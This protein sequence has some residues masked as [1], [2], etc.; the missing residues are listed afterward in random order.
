MGY[1]YYVPMGPFG[2]VP[3]SFHSS[4][5]ASVQNTGECESVSVW[6]LGQPEVLPI[7]QLVL[8]L[9]KEQG[10]M[11]HLNTSYVENITMEL[12]D[13]AP[14]SITAILAWRDAG[15]LAIYLICIVTD[16]R[17]V[18]LG[19]QYFCKAAQDA[20]GIAAQEGQKLGDTVTHGLVTTLAVDCPFEEQLRL[21]GRHQEKQSA[22]HE[23]T[24]LVTDARFGQR[25]Q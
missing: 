17:L 9:K 16:D 25:C 11:R 19:G 7:R 24:E 18:V 21:A 5:M 13:E 20:V 8:D 2:A 6:Q 4:R 15:M 23:V 3:E 1:R 22:H 10:Q 12:M 14:I